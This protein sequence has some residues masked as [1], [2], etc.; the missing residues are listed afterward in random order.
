[1]NTFWATF[2][3]NSATF[4]SNICGQTGPPLVRSKKVLWHWSL[5]D[6]PD[7]VTDEEDDDDADE[8]LR[9]SLAGGPLGFDRG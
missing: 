7:D 8:K 1:M 9:R 2:V 4:Y 6:E 5:D 3:E